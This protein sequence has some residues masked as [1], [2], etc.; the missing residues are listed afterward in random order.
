[1]KQNEKKTQGKLFKVNRGILLFLGNLTVLI[2]MN[3]ELE[4]KY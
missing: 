3:G 4:F 1:M 2:G